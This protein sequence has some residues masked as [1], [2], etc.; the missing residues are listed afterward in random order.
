[1]RLKGVIDDKGEYL[2]FIRFGLQVTGDNARQYRG[3][4]MGQLWRYRLDGRQEAERLA[5]AHQGSVRQVQLWRDK[6][7]L[8]SDRDG[9]AN[10]WQLALDGSN[11]Q[12]LTQ[13]Q[14]FPVRSFQG[15]W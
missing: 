4:A 12:A 13:H 5:A 6:I 15:G 14:D 9:Q 8:L 1:M 11:A 7:L 3:G 2:Y 10:I